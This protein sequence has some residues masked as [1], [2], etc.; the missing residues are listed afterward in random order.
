[1]PGIPEADLAS[2][3]DCLDEELKQDLGEVDEKEG[4]RSIQRENTIEI[5]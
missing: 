5:T 1:M 4:P 3:G 2:D